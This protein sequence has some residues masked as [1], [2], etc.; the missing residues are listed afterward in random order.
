M[1][2]RKLGRLEERTATKPPAL[3]SDLSRRLAA[4]RPFSVS[5]PQPPTQGLQARLALVADR[6]RQRRG[7]SRKRMERPHP[8]DKLLGEMREWLASNPLQSREDAYRAIG[9]D[10][11]EA[12]KKA[13]LR[14]ERR[15]RHLKS[16]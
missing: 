7:R 9:G 10:R 1:I 6:I 3:P 5:Q 8:G 2:Q 16:G 15:E 14:A 13:I 12:V 4:R 11:A